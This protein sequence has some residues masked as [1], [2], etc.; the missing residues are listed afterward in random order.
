MREI[1]FLA[2]DRRD[3]AEIALGNDGG[4]VGLK[5]LRVA[6]SNRYNL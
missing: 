5:M 3:V 2:V 4:G 1:D 6:A